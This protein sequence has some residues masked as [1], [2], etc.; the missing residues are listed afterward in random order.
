MSSGARQLALLLAVL[1]SVLAAYSLGGRTAPVTSPA[2]EHV[3]DGLA[4]QAAALDLGEVW[5]Q[6]DYVCNLPIRNRIGQDVNV[7]EFAVSC[8]C[9]VVEPRTITIPPGE[10]VTVRLTLNLAERAEKNIDLPE[11]PLLV[12]VVPVFRGG[13]SCPRSE[14]GKIRLEAARHRQESGNSS[15]TCRSLSRTARTWASTAGTHRCGQSSCARAP[16]RCRSQA[17][18]SERSGRA[19]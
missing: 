10:T 5:E 12:E 19:L 7:A 9:L 17:G 2:N 13:G 6:R 1:I 15:A 4:V 8:Q 18:D 11:R 3:I 16:P 14:I